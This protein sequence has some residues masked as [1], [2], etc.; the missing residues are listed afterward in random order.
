MGGAADGNDAGHALGVTHAE[1][2]ADGAAKAVTDE[3]TPVRTR[4]G[5]D[6]LHHRGDVELVILFEGRRVRATGIAAAAVSA[7]LDVVGVKARVDETV[8]EAPLWQVPGEP[9]LCEPV[10]EHDGHGSRVSDGKSPQHRKSVSVCGG[11]RPRLL[12]EADAA[13]A[14][15]FGGDG[16]GCGSFD[17]RHHRLGVDGGCCDPAVWDTIAATRTVSNWVPVRPFQRW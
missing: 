11:H 8:L 9:V 16:L 15:D 14:G 17:R 3:Q 1:G 4:G 6:R 10:D 12:D 13:G 7:K 2:V 5:S